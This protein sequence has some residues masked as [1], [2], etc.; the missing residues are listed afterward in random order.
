[1]EERDLLDFSCTVGAARECTH[2]C[3]YKIRESGAQTPAGRSPET[4]GTLAELRCFTQYDDMWTVESRLCC[5]I[6]HAEPPVTPPSS[7]LRL[8]W[9]WESEVTFSTCSARLG[10]PASAS[11]PGALYFKNCIWKEIFLLFSTDKE[12]KKI[13]KIAIFF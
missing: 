5:W 13:S 4:W 6:D 2:A 3:M 7:E 9:E 8:S 12:G 11:V 1:M 10:F